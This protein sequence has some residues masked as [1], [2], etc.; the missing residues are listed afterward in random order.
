V[1]LFSTL[2]DRAVDLQILFLCGAIL[3]LSCVFRLDE[4]GCIVVGG[5]DA[6]P[7]PE[8]C[9]FKL[10]TGR[11]CPSCGMVRSFT[12]MSHLDVPAA[13]GFNRVGP[14]VYLFVLAQVPYR[15]L[16]IGWPAF[17]RRTDRWD[18]RVALGTLMVLLVVLIL[19]WILK[20]ARV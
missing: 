18:G 13:W 11:D 7:L 6:E 3:V 20:L 14:L 2:A 12:A 1:G 4:D 10:S 9:I 8:T 16:R 17:R 19:N 15:L 5:P